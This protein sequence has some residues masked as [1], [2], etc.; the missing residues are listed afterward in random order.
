LSQG[1]GLILSPAAAFLT[2]YYGPWPISVAQRGAVDPNHSVGIV[3]NLSITAY[4]V[5]AAAQFLGR[6]HP[7]RVWYVAFRTA[8]EDEA[9]V[10]NAIKERGYDV[11]IAERTVKGTLYLGVLPSS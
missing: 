8:E 2:G 6:T 5:A 3:R 11:G 1:D 9:G 4:P 7:E 10:V